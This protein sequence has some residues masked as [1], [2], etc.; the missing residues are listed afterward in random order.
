MRSF[1]VLPALLVVVICLTSIGYTRADAVITSER[2]NP[3]L[4]Y[5]HLV[6]PREH[7][8]YNRRPVKP[9]NWDTFGYRIQFTSIR[10]F[11]MQGDKIVDYE[12]EIEKYTRKHDLGN[13][14]WPSYP[15]LFAKNLGDLLDEIKRR[16][17]YL[18]DIWGYVPGSGPGGFSEQI[19]VPP[20]VLNTI[21]SK[22]GERWLGTDIG[23]QDGRYIGGY[24]NQMFPASASRFDQYLNFQRHFERM[25]DDLGHKHAVL[26]S[27]NY[28]HYLLK[29]RTFTLIGAE[30]GQALPNNQ[31][32]YAFVRGA[33]KQYGV[34]WFGNVS[35]WNRWGVKTYESAGR[36]ND[37]YEYGPTKGTSLSLMKRLLYSHI[38]Y[39]CMVVGFEYGWFER[40]KLSPLGR[41]QQEAQKWVK[42]HG[43]PGVMHTPVALLLDFYSGWT[44]PRHLYTK[45]IYRVWGNLSYG[46][47][48]YLTDSILDM[49]YPAYRDSSY[50]HDETGFN[51]P[52]P[53][54]DIA[55]CLLSD[56]PLW[57]LKRYAVII[58]AGELTGGREIRDKLQAYVEAGG[59]LAITAGN[60]AKLPGG[61]AE[62]SAERDKPFRSEGVGIKDEVVDRE[63]PFEAW[64]LLYPKSAVILGIAQGSSQPVVLRAST[65][66]GMVT[67]FASPYGIRPSPNRL[68]PDLSTFDA[69]LISPFPLLDHVKQVIG[70]IFAKQRLFEVSGEDLSL[71]TCRRARGNYT[72]GI[73]NNGWQERAFKIT[74]RCGAIE[75]IHELPLDQSEKDALG[76]FPEGIDFKAVGK[77][78]GGT[79]AGGDVRIFTVQV[80]EQGVEDLPHT[81][82]PERL[83]GLILTLRQPR[84]IKEEIL[85]RSTF[86]EHFD[87]VV[88]DW[89][90]LHERES[91]VLAREGNWIRRQGLQ[92]FV[93][94][95][96]G[97]NLFPDLRLTDNLDR[98]YSASMAAI[99]NV[100]NKMPTIGARDLILSLH[101][102]PEDNFTGEQARSA[103]EK[104][105]CLLAKQAAEHGI[106]LHLRL[107]P[108]KPPASLE[109]AVRLLERVAAPNLKITPSVA[110][111]T[112]TSATTEKIARLK[113]IVGLWSLSSARKD[114]T[115]QIWDIHTP[116]HQASNP[117]DL[118]KWLSLIS[119][120]PIVLD[121]IYANQDEEYLDVVELEK[122][123]SF[124]Q[125]P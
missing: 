56:A 4:V 58:V 24:A 63:S 83:R 90:Y 59:H 102:H 15:I 49:L 35:V 117:G 112:V 22:L 30:T 34:P 10:S 79:I 26:V 37:G 85:R 100:L 45:K 1:C 89:R 6:D 110:M 11:N 113:N 31:V 101:R 78:L 61:I 114:I 88:V 55:D 109:D 91:S 13:V 32:Y 71:I 29:E 96:S 81:K 9:P 116:I 115:G 92:V 50:F 38:L 5:S 20:D 43:Q 2:A 36:H 125:E 73:A 76:Y 72:L 52:T 121:A 70:D 14:I 118:A 51:V 21:E 18:F 74:S 82:P 124:K 7:P 120:A 16:N 75:S 44:F 25:G 23:E 65:G 3:I 77:S 57:L 66:K 119:E 93:D 95:T 42:D 105:L 111:L 62:V 94:L 39:N 67:V 60:L 8:D 53:Y 103:F 86:F 122:L 41:I 107:A 104:T 40:D 54:G 47:G 33:G 12:E 19:K 106:I 27:L 98:E 28:G 46:P 68:P 69:P 48:D 97:L 99:M 64:P 80:K 123:K 84:S 108:G 17:L 87:G